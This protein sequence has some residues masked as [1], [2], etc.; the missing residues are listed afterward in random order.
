[1]VSL[2]LET[3]DNDRV[4]SCGP[5]EHLQVPLQHTNEAIHL[6]QVAMS[7]L[8]QRE[9]TMPVERVTALNGR[10]MFVSTISLII[11]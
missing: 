11:L 7:S 4:M 3:C 10:H 5:G 1:M 2:T 8:N 6:I 9:E